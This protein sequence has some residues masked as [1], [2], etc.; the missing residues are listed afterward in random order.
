MEDRQ[1]FLGNTVGYLLS[2]A[3]TG[4]PPSDDYAKPTRGSLLG[5][6]KALAEWYDETHAGNFNMVPTIL[7]MYATHL[8]KYDNAVYWASKGIVQAREKGNLFS[9]S[10]LSELLIAS[11]LG[12]K[13]YQDVVEFAFE[14]ATS[15]AALKIMSEETAFDL[16]AEYDAYSILGPPPNNKWQSVEDIFIFRCV[17]PLLFELYHAGNGSNTNATDIAEWI[18]QKSSMV[19][20]P[21]ESA[22]NV[23]ARFLSEG[24]SENLQKMAYDV[25]SDNIYG[26]GAIALLLSSFCEDADLKYSILSHAVAMHAFSYYHQ[27]DAMLWS[28]WANELRAYWL[29]KL[30]NARFLFTTPSFIERE[31]REMND[32]P[33]DGKVKSVLKI[34]MAGLKVGF[35]PVFDNT[36]KWLYK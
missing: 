24:N 34:V 16:T 5:F 8:Q 32:M 11:K 31:L 30:S 21:L 3:M 27:P 35:H 18:L 28:Y 1:A 29:L 2:M 6:N 25:R 23:H 10:K 20:G 26:P 13:E 14:S 17:L 12:T 36:K 19:N 33:P 9:I 15:T 22:M 4:S 7:A